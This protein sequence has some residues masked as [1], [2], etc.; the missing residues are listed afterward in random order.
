MLEVAF[1][2][3]KFCHSL[4]YKQTISVIPWAE[5]EAKKMG[6]F[7]SSPKVSPATEG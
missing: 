7:S 1:L 3:H 2:S 6:T 5:S 4:L